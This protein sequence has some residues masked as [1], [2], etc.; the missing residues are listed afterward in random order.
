[1]EPW[2]LRATCAGFGDVVAATG[3]STTARSRA[4][5]M[6]AV[7][8]VFAECVAEADTLPRRELYLFRHGMSVKEQLRR[9]DRQSGSSSLGRRPGSRSK[10]T[11]RVVMLTEA[12]NSASEIE[13]IMGITRRTVVRH[14]TT[15]RAQGRLPVQ[16]C[17]A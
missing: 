15:A 11:D 5:Q 12:G 14:R 8:P 16:V 2:Q 4:E 6:C 7:C 13:A 3:R 17:V 1:M 9:R 10:I